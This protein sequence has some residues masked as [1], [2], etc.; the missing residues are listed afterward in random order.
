MPRLHALRPVAILVVVPL[1]VALLP[2]AE[3]RAGDAD[4]PITTP[5][6]TP[7]QKRIAKL[8]TSSRQMTAYSRAHPRS[9][10]ASV[11][12]NEDT[13]HIALWWKG[14]IPDDVE[15]AVKA[16]RAKGIRVVV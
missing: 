7:Q 5:A 4:K 11:I 16:A 8:H 14:A 1:L 2:A 3:A 10:Y 12:T 15:S 9:G 6:V 13:S